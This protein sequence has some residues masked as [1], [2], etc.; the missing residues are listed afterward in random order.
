[1]NIQQMDKSL[2]YGIQIRN[3]IFHCPT[4]IRCLMTE[5][6]SNL[7][8]CPLKGGRSICQVWHLKKEL[9]KET[10]FFWNYIEK[11]FLT[12]SQEDLV[13]PKK[14]ELEMEQRHFLSLSFL[15]IG[16]YL[17]ENKFQIPKSWG[18][19]ARM[20]ADYSENPQD[21]FRLVLEDLWQDPRNS[22]LMLELIFK[23]FKNTLMSEKTQKGV[24]LLLFILKKA[25]DE[26]SNPIPEEEP[27]A[28]INEIISYLRLC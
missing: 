25:I 27:E 15:G 13:Y 7:L 19:T 18:T 17:A 16:K 24:L 20:L 2:L 14:M 4:S 11:T 23:D 21:F 3:V 8:T 5:E 9:E 26:S 10:P 22:K 1:M 12:I 28:T 6:G